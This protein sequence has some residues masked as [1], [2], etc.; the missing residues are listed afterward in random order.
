MKRVEIDPKNLE[1]TKEPE[2]KPEANP[3]DRQISLEKEEPLLGSLPP[4]NPEKTLLARPREVSGAVLTPEH[5]AA[6]S[7]E[8][9]ER[10]LSQVPASPSAKTVLEMDPRETP[11]ELPGAGFEEAMAQQ[12][13]G[14]GTLPAYSSLDELLQGT[15]AVSSSTAPILMP[16]DLLFEYDASALRPEAERTLEKLGSL[17]RRNGGAGFRIEGHTDSFGSEDYNRQLS[18]RRAEAVKDWL[19]SR[20][21]IDPARITTVGFGKSRLLIA[22]TGSIAQQQLNR[23]VEIVITTP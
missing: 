23:R 22:A 4:L 3:R 1:E 2:K 17:I 8:G 7:K 12:G 9:L 18:L 14:T 16:T 20:M 15:G 5:D 13:T 6:A 21:G 11:K 10:L 19:V